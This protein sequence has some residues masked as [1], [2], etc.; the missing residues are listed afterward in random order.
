MP[1]NFDSPPPNFTNPLTQSLT[2]NTA[3]QHIFSMLHVLYFYINKLE[4]EH[5]TNKV[6]SKVI[7]NITN[8]EDTIY[9]QN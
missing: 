8:K 6:T 4:K 2:N 7:S 5:I 3:N 9:V 1:I